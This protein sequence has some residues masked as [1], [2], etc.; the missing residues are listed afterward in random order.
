MPG[1]AAKGAGNQPR[2]PPC[3]PVGG[4]A[5]AAAGKLHGLGTADEAAAWAEHT[6]PLKNTLTALDAQSLETAFAVGIA[7]LSGG[8]AP[9]RIGLG[10]PAQLPSPSRL[11][12]RAGSRRV[13]Q[14]LPPDQTEVMP[15][16]GLRQAADRR[17]ALKT[18]RLRD[19][20]RF[21][22]AALGF[23]LVFSARPPAWHRGRS[24]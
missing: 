11:T 4:T 2:T 23:L 20:T 7:G 17:L 12:R 9:R 1:H 24:A 5:G 3:G 18:I 21:C 22:A 19:K 15:R 6:L 8:S 16:N 10:R 13:E 14:G